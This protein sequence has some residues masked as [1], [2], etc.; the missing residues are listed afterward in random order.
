[1]RGQSK[2]W[3]LICRRGDYGGKFRFSHLSSYATQAAAEKDVP[4]KFGNAHPNIMP[5]IVLVYLG[6][7]INTWK[8]PNK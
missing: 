8:N 3:K 6:N 7:T 1:V 2:N 4:S 5:E